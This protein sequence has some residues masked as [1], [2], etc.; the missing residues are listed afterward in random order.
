[1]VERDYN[2]GESVVYGFGSG[3]GWALAIA[4]LAGIQRKNEI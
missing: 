1:M 3:L 4:A 2:F